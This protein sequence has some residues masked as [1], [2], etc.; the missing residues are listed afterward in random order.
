VNNE[1]RLVGLLIAI[2]AQIGKR[3]PLKN[4]ILK[5]IQFLL[6]PGILPTE[7]ATQHHQAN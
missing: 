7:L 1:E 6:L 3:F 4:S 2:Q 5:V